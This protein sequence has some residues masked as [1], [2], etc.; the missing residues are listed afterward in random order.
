MMLKLH[1]KISFYT[2][3][4]E[5]DIEGILNTA[6][7]SYKIFKIPKN[8]GGYR[9]IAQPNRSTKAIQYALLDTFFNFIE[10]SKIATAYKKGSSPLTDNTQPHATFAYSLKTDFKNFFP[11]I[12]PVDLFQFF[13]RIY[14]KEL[15][16][17]DREVIKRACFSKH[18]GE[19][20]LSIGA[21]T[22][23]IISNIVMSNLDEQIYNLTKSIDPKSVITRYAD[24]L[25]FSTNLKDVSY[26]FYKELTRL[27]ENTSSPNLELNKS[28][29]IYLSKKD[30][31]T[32]TGLVIT[33][34]GSIS[35]G[36][37][38]KRYI[39]S[40]VF[41]MKKN[42]LEPEKINHLK[43]LL[44]FANDIEPEFYN[45]LITKYGSEVIQKIKSS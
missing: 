6:P 44:G 4:S 45:R 16:T 26:K 1:S 35:I 21:P 37:K 15:D 27:L 20:A 43:G 40:M 38:R 9:T 22:S 31:R 28:K 8:S 23:P 30:N 29:T 42:I 32:I 10:I 36:R 5:S 3:L 34:Q 12:L 41:K 18:T 2:G 14:S 19:Y 11:S 24:D 33:P 17:I 39:K 7:Y 25:T 13:E